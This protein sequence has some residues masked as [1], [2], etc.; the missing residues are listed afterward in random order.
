MFFT[1]NNI[2]QKLLDNDRFI[3][4]YIEKVRSTKVTKD[5]ALSAFRQNVNT[6]EL[7]TYEG[8][9]AEHLRVHHDYILSSDSKKRYDDGAGNHFMQMDEIYTKRLR[10]DFSNFDEEAAQ[11]NFLECKSDDYGVMF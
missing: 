6:L 8:A 7:S 11:E 10:A 4:Q 9:Y 2:L 1:V 3:K 5:A